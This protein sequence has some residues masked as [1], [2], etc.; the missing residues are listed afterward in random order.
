MG[1]LV[2]SRRKKLGKAKVAIDV[3]ARLDPP[4][5]QDQGGLS[6]LEEGLHQDHA[7]GADGVAL[8]CSIDLEKLGGGSTW[9][10]DI[11][12]FFL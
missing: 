4:L 1:V 2:Y 12:F 11:I 9:V 3:D 5:L 8:P 10:L 6:S 7:D